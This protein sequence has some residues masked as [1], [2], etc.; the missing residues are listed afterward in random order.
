M[1]SPSAPKKEPKSKTTKPPPIQL[2]LHEKI[3][4]RGAYST[5]SILEPVM[6]IERTD[7]ILCEDTA[8]KGKKEIFYRISLSFDL[9]VG[10][11]GFD[12]R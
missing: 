12:S 11:R 4:V 7:P 6:W 8:M 3:G 5:V 2:N 10:I 9:Q 1:A